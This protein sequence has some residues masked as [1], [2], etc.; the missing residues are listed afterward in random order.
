M[1]GGSAWRMVVVE[2]QEVRIVDGTKSSAGV[3]RGS[4]GKVKRKRYHID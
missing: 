3:C 2:E 1:A 4:L